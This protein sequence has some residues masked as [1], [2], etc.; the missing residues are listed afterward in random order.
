MFKLLSV[1]PDVNFLFPASSSMQAF[2][3]KEMKGIER[4]NN[5]FFALIGNVSNTE[6]LNLDQKRMLT[7]SDAAAAKYNFVG[8]IGKSKS[9]FSRSRQ[10][11][12]SV[13]KILLYCWFVF[14]HPPPSS[15]FL[16]KMLLSTVIIESLPQGRDVIYGRP[17]Y[18][19]LCF[20]VWIAGLFVSKN[21]KNWRTRRRMS[22]KIECKL[23]QCCHL[24]F[25]LFLDQ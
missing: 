25:F 10:I 9:S 16:V 12:Y 5:C 6:R 13:L 24:A 14:G 22:L 7:L 23:R 19:R 8:I 2:Q 11:S 17:F 18:I 3:A 21:Q 4:K 20:S 15:R 1:N